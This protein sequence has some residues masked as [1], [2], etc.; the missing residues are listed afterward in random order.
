MLFREWDVRTDLPPQRPAGP[1]FGIWQHIS[2]TTFCD[3]QALFPPATKMSNLPNRSKPAGQRLGASQGWVDGWIQ[4][5]E[6]RNHSWWILFRQLIIL[7]A[8]C[9]SHSKTR[10]V[11]FRAIT[12]EPSPGQTLLQTVNK[13]SLS[14]GRRARLSRVEILHEPLEGFVYAFHRDEETG[15]GVSHSSVV[16]R[17]LRVSHTETPSHRQTRWLLGERS[18]HCYSPNIT[19]TEDVKRYLPSGQE[20]PKA[21]DSTTFPLVGCSEFTRAL[22][23]EILVRCWWSPRDETRLGCD[24][25]EGWEYKLVVRLKSRPATPLHHRRRRNRDSTAGGMVS[26]EFALKAP[27]TT[28]LLHDVVGVG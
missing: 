14:H 17:K 10:I 5:G 15:V 7:V 9:Y 4:A 3:P 20:S 16:L 2:T 8:L 26:L 11:R 18:R 6:P 1:P 27:T 24:E 21:N 22:L 28:P 23:S 12:N 25:P 13:Q 19:R